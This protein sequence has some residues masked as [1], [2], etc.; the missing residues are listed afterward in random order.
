MVKTI[1]FNETHW[2]IKSCQ[3]DF[4]RN[5]TPFTVF[6]HRIVHQWPFQLMTNLTSSN[7]KTCRS[8]CRCHLPWLPAPR[9]ARIRA[10]GGARYCKQK[11]NPRHQAS[12]GRG[13]KCDATS[14]RT[15]SQSLEV[16]RCPLRVAPSLWNL[17]GV[18]AALLPRR[19]SNSRATQP[20]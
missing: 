20:F 5:F 2:F 3:K 7:L 12:G 6:K 9:M 11:K 8:S 17:T 4:K 15:I 14:Y 16:A 18:S 1:W 10:V 13:W 19:L